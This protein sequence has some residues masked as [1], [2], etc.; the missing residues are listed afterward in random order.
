MSLQSAKIQLKS[1]FDVKKYFSMLLEST[2]E[3]KPYNDAK[4]VCMDGDIFSNRLLL[5]LTFPILETPI[6][7]LG[8]SMET[9]V[10]LPDYTVKG[11]LQEIKSFLP[12]PEMEDLNSGDITNSVPSYK[13][14][15]IEKIFIEPKIEVFETDKTKESYF[16]QSSGFECEF[17]ECRAKLLNKKNLKQ[18]INN[19]H[20]NKDKKKVYTCHFCTANFV[21]R[22]EHKK[23]LERYKDEAGGYKCP[24][25]HCDSKFK[26]RTSL[27]EHVRRHVGI[28]R[29]Q[30]EKCE[31]LFASKSILKHHLISHVDPTI[32]CDLCN[33]LFKTNTALKNHVNLIHESRETI[34][35]IKKKA[36]CDQCD[37]EFSSRFRMKHHIL[38]IHNDSRDFTCGS[39][40][41]TFKTKNDVTKHE[42]I[43]SGIKTHKCSYC[44]KRFLA[45]YKVRKHEVIHTGVMEY[46]C[47]KCGKRFNQKCNQNTHE[48][49]CS[50]ALL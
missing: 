17:E 7:S 39:C 34:R 18:H 43:H 33:K 10:V 5:F 32:M 16:A 48:R 11:L 6:S 30:C 37:K 25:E 28:F 13:I 38:Y 44:E 27:L 49:K 21:D 20:F 23:H 19:V 47:S 42:K 50:E 15:E 41:K 29:M 31:R 8:E 35:K 1:S 3:N 26:G 12:G 46:S 24:E 22:D 45:P 40:G 9:V 14:E 36:K 2:I 4:I